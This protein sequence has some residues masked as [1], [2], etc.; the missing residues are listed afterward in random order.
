MKAV[1][2][3][4]GQTQVATDCTN[5]VYM[6]YPGSKSRGTQQIW[7]LRA[8][9]KMA[10]ERLRKGRGAG[11]NRNT[12]KSASVMTRWRYQI[13]AIPTRTCTGAS[14]PGSLPAPMRNWLWGS[15]HL[16]SCYP[17]SPLSPGHPQ[18]A[19]HAVET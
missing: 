5:S 10:M 14:P 1:L 11:D 15:A 19:K 18:T 6:R 9:N 13:P 12:L 3:E 16:P 4:R 17:C 7:L 8:R 2:T